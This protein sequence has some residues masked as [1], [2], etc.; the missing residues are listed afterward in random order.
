[1]HFAGFHVLK[2]CNSSLASGNRLPRLCN[3]LPEMKSLEAHLLIACSGYGTLCVAIV[4]RSLV[5]ESTPFLL[6]LVDRDG[7]ATNP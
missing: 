1:V 3:R 5:K 4:V 7:S 6:F 2:L